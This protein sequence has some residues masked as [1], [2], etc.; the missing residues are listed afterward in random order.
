[1]RFVPQRI[2]WSNGICRLL[3]PKLKLGNQRDN[4]IG[5]ADSAV[6]VAGGGLPLVHKRYSKLLTIVDVGSNA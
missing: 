6:G 1:M 4:R 3:V 2:L 5:C